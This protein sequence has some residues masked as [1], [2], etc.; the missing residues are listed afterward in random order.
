MKVKDE[1]KLRP[2]DSRIECVG[3]CQTRNWMYWN[4]VP[5][6]STGSYACNHVFIF[7]LDIDIFIMTA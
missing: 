3:N 1:W 5:I 6:V 4:V 7:E 2:L